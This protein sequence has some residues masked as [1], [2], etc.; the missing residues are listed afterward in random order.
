MV[1][2]VYMCGWYGYLFR[3]GY[4]SGVVFSPMRMI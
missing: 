1:K 2:Q 4:L 3:S